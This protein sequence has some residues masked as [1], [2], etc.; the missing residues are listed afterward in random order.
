MR[1]EHGHHWYEKTLCEVY[2]PHQVR[3]PST[4]R[5]CGLGAVECSRQFVLLYV[6]YNN[7]VSYIYI[8]MNM[9]SK[10]TDCAGSSRLHP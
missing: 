6:I 5:K 1:A 9:T 3:P 10:C 4:G 2:L 8:Y 7:L